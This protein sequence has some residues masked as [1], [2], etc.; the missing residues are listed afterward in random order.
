MPSARALVI[1][2]ERVLGHGQAGAD[3]PEKELFAQDVHGAWSPKASDGGC[4]KI[5]E[6]FIF[7]HYN[8]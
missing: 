6:I 1:E 8:L 3:E 7:I 4:Q 5:Y 2:N